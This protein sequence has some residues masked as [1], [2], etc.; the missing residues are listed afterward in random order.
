M[1]AFF[2]FFIETKSRSVTQAG[3]QWPDLSSLQPL[4]PGFKRFSCL[5][6]LNSGDY[7]HPPPPCPANFCIFSG[8]ESLS[9]SHRLQ[10]NGTIMAH[11]SLDLPGSSVPP[12]LASQVPRTIVGMEFCHVSQGGL[13]LLGSSDLPPWPL[14]VLELQGLE[15]S[16]EISA[17]SNL[18]LLG[19]SDSPASATRLAE[20]TGV[21]HHAW[22]IFVFLLKTGFRHELALSPRLECSDTIMVH[23]SLNI[24][25]S[26]DPP[27]AASQSAGITWCES[28]DL[29]FL[30]FNPNAQSL[31]YA[32]GI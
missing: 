28:L 8:D 23:C 24:P 13:K 21:H 7:R 19:S 6:L 12:T 3:V 17:H 30:F 22:L 9:L 25:G 26:S 15:C 14:K 2:L 20:I 27:T 29:A 11:C 1:S 5:S 18:C 10:C 31:I 32:N 4:P 16:G